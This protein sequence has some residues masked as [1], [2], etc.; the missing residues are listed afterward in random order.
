MKR[1]FLALAALAASACATDPVTPGLGWSRAPDLS[2]YAAME[3]FGLLAREEATYCAGFAP[4]SVASDWQDDYGRREAAVI[5]ALSARHGQAAVERAR[6]A[7]VPPSRLSC[8]EL[9]RGGW[10]DDHGRLLRL[11][12]IRLGLA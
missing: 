3:E 4:A 5:A 6:A 1:V 11:L 9:P 12:E 10:R 8:P 2:V 7:G